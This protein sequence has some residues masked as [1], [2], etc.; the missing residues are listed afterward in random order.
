[1]STV[2]LDNKKYDLDNPVSGEKYWVKVAEKELLNRKIVEVRYLSKEE[3]DDIGWYK[4]PLVFR[5]DDD[6][7]IVP[8]MDDEGNDGGVLSTKNRVLPSL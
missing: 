4:R 8:Q 6:N 1:M 7:W 2:T 3:A 5:L